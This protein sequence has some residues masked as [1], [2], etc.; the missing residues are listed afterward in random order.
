MAMASMLACR[1]L[2][3]LPQQA[4][5]I[6][7]T[8]ALRMPPQARS[9][10]TY[11]QLAAWPPL[12]SHPDS[13]CLPTP[14][15]LHSRR[16]FLAAQTQAAAPCVTR[17]SLLASFDVPHS[18]DCR[19]MRHDHVHPTLQPSSLACRSRLQRTPG[20]RATQSWCPKPTPQ[21]ASGATGAS[22]A[23]AGTPSSP[24]SRRCSSTRTIT[25]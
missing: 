17:L 19:V 1:A 24:T 10:H 7:L 22:S 20:T 13:P 8:S 3:C 5:W 18:A 23:V 11:Q 14:A 15:R 2:Y 21:T 9:P 25:R 16:C 6:H 12:T 4:I